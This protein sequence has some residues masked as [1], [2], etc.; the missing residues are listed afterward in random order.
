MYNHTRRL[1]LERMEKD[2]PN[3]AATRWW[4]SS[5]G[6]CQGPAQRDPHGGHRLVQPALGQATRPVTWELTGE[7]LWNLTQLGYVAGAAGAWVRRCTP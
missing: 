3:A 7:E 4:T 6:S 1:A 5:H 2:A